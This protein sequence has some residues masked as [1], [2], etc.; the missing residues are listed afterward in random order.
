[1]ALYE[2]HEHPDLDSPVLI[3]ALEGWI[4]AGAG[5]ARATA[6]LTDALD[7]VLV[8]TFDTDVL[9]DHRARRP[10]MQLLDGV[11]TGLEWP[12]I[13]LRAATDGAGHDLLLLVGAE[14]DHT[15]RAFASASVDLAMEFGV[16]LVLGLGAYPAPVPHT[17][18]TSLASTATSTELAQQVGSVGGAINVP[19]GIQGAIERRCFEVGIPAVGLWAQVPHYAAAMPYPAA[20]AALVDGLAEVGGLE[21]DSQE[22]HQEAEATRARLDSLV[23]ESEEHRE[24]VRQ[25]EAHVDAEDSP[26]P[27]APLEMQSGD[28]LAEELERFLRDQDG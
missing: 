28:E 17:R 5:A 3:M 7:S 21:L 24:L 19:A 26:E 23:A 1:M 11:N 13:E 15:W 2:I 9:L 22:L 25:L 18:P 6:A 27:A 12:T 16:R 8:A 14:P 10:V 20:A 4:D